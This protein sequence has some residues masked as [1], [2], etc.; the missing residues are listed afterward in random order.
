MLKPVA[1]G[2][3]ERVAVTMLTVKSG[4]SQEKTSV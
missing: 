3:T 1:A 2:V 4:D